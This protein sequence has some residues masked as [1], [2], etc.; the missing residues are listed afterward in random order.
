MALCTSNADLASQCGAV[1][2][3]LSPY[4]LQLQMIFP[5]LHFLL[6]RQ[7]QL[8]VPGNY[9]DFSCPTRFTHCVNLDLSFPS[10]QTLQHLQRNCCLA[11]VAQRWR[12]N[13]QLSRCLA[14]GASRWRVNLT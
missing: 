13:L 12:M 9:G 11:P 4:R 1:P 14:L 8:C 6:E 5:E 7:I 2:I 3:F 10:T